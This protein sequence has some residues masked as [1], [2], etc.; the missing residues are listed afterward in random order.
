MV[1]VVVLELLDV[2]PNAPLN[3]QHPT[4]IKPNIASN[5]LDRVQLILAQVRVGGPELIRC[6]HPFHEVTKRV[7]IVV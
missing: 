4:V 1:D 3:A 2:D 7:P 5:A 6:H